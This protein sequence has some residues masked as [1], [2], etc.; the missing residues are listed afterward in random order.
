[1]QFKT[2][3]GKRGGG[4]MSLA[5]STGLLIT[6][7]FLILLLLGVPIGIGLIVASIVAI[8]QSLGFSASIPSSALK[9]FQ[10]INIFTLLAIPFF[11]LAGNIMNKGGIALRLVIQLLH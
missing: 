4:K 2:I 11:I 5:L 7:T 6:V 3:L 8:I 9:M 10:G 1:M